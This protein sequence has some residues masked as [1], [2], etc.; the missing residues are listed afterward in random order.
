MS[1]CGR[2]T[3]KEYICHEPAPICQSQVGKLSREAFGIWDLDPLV[4]RLRLAMVTSTEPQCTRT[5][6]LTLVGSCRSLLLHNRVGAMYLS[7]QPHGYTSWLLNMW[8][9]AHAHIAQQH[10]AIFPHPSLSLQENPADWQ[11]NK[12]S[13]SSMRSAI[14]RESLRRR[15]TGVMGWAHKRA[16]SSTWPRTIIIELPLAHLGCCAS[17]R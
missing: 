14:S 7:V 1:M 17:T 11:V 9:T 13:A 8:H 5:L 15:P 10:S 12:K 3:Y 4:M 2:R 16:A 6:C